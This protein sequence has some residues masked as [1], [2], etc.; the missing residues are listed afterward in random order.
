MF[1]QFKRLSLSPLLGLAAIPALTAPA[2][3]GEKPVIVRADTHDLRVERISH[4]S[5]NL[6]DARDLK[7]LNFRV[8][9]AAQR[10]C[11]RDFGRDGLQDRGYY[12]CEGRALS[13]AKSQIDEAV[14]NAQRLALNGLSPV[15]AIAITVS[16]S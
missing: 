12:A 1:G 14:A 10:V 4:A 16:A 13:S 8:A 11:Q 2:S 3:A 6:T 5:L 7:S 9:G 15:A